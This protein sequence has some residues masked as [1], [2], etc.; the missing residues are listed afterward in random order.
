MKTV[1]RRVFSIDEEVKEPVRE[2]GPNT[3]LPKPLKM[4]FEYQIVFDTEE[5]A[6]E[7]INLLEIMK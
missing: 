7:I 6:K 5:E 2:G 1:K 3:I 4:E